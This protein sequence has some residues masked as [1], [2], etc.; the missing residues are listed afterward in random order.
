MLLYES[1]QNKILCL[2]FGKYDLLF[3]LQEYFGAF[4]LVCYIARG[5]FDCDESGGQVNLTSHHTHYQAASDSVHCAGTYKSETG[6]AD[7][8]LGSATVQP[9]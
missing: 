8:H 3:I 7:G 2:I 1:F 5:I 9:A 4:V 6:V